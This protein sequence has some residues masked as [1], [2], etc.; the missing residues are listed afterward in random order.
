MA[1]SIP[2]LSNSAYARHQG[3][4]DNVTGPLT[5]ALINIEEIA[6]EVEG[7]GVVLDTD[8][9]ATANLIASLRIRLVELD[10]SLD[11]LDAADAAEEYDEE[12][13]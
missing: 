13:D 9:E 1:S 10:N 7:E 12:E 2:H 3:W 5:R 11:R 4:E 6:C 8:R